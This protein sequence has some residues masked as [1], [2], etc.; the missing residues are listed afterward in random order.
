MEDVRFEFLGARRNPKVSLAGGPREIKK[1][2]YVFSSLDGKRG[3]CRVHRISKDADTIKSWYWGLP[4]RV[5]YQG[6]N[7]PFAARKVLRA[8]LR[9]W[10]ITLVI[11]IPLV[12]SSC[13]EITPKLE[14]RDDYMF[15]RFL[16][17]NR[18]VAEIRRDEL[19]N[20]VLPKSQQ[21][22]VVN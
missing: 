13:A 14:L 15:K 6:E 12:T 21:Q 17:P 2:T 16:Q 7:L 11:G 9:H 4:V 20:A 3:E 19:G 8:L 1:L 22:P 5:K 18:V 10:I